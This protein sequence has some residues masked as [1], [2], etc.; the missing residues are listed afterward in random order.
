MTR[1]THKYGDSA[2]FVK[3]KDA[4]EILLRDEMCERIFER[5]DMFQHQEI[6]PE[7]VQDI[8]SVECETYEQCEMILK[9]LQPHGWTFS[10]YLDAQPYNLTEIETPAP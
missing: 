6:L 7:K 10:Y 3:D 1:I 2:I 5:V 9:A 4:V 8:I